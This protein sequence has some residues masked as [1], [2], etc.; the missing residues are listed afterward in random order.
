MKQLSTGDCLLI[1]PLTARW[2]YPSPFEGRSGHLH[3]ASHVYHKYRIS[4]MPVVE[5]QG[6]SLPFNGH[7]DGLVCK[8]KT[9]TDSQRACGLIPGLTLA[10]LFSCLRNIDGNCFF[11]LVLQQKS[12]VMKVLIKV[13]SNLQESLKDN[14]S[15]LPPSKCLS[16]FPSLCIVISSLG[17]PSRKFPKPTI[18]GSVLTRLL[19][20]NSI[21]FMDRDDRNTLVHLFGLRHQ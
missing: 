1:A 21:S 8:I 15:Y 20:S 3:S 10:S 11:S 9:W 4:N 13:K 16:H 5:S 18:L 2:K 12:N 6:P 14:Y 17:P 19:S 7:W